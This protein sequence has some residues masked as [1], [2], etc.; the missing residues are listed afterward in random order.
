[1]R[2]L[3]EV[4]YEVLGEPNMRIMCGEVEACSSSPHR[5]RVEHLKELM[6]DRKPYKHQ[7]VIPNPPAGTILGLWANAAGQGGVLPIEACTM[8]SSKQLEV[9]LTGSLGDVMK[10]S[11]HVARTLAL[12]RVVSRDTWPSIHIHTP[13]GATSKDGPSAGMAIT[14]AL[15]GLLDGKKCKHDLACTGEIHL[16]GHVGAIGGLDLKVMGG[17]RAGVKHFLYPKENQEDMDDIL[18]K[19]GAL[20]EYSGATYTAVDC[21]DEALALAYDED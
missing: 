5:V 3:K 15:I 21:L 7:M 14:L 4:L 17:L 2:K 10:E 19:Y 1:M 18:T 16:N 13:D 12:H 20:P 9:K 11:M 6:P 8:Q